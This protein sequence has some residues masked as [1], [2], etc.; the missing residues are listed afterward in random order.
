MNDPLVQANQLKKYYYK[1]TSWFRKK[2]I[3][4]RAIDNVSFSIPSGKIVGLIGESGSGKTTLA[5][6][7]SGLLSLTSGYLSFDNTP[8]NLHS[9]HDLKKLRSHVRM[10]FQNPKASLNPRKT[11][12]DSLGHAL[13]HHRIITKDKLH[14]VIGETLERVGLSAD[15]FYY[16]PHQLSGGQQ[17][18]VSIAR[19]LLG[20]PKLIICDEVVSA[21][22]LSMQAQILNML[23]KLQ[24][25]LQMSYLFISHDLAVV[26]S[27]CSEVIIMYKG[28]IVE[29]GATED[30]FLNPKHPYTQMLLNSQLADLPEN[31]SIEHKLKSFQ[32]NSSENPSPT[33]C[34]FY[35]RCP[36]RQ[37][38]CLQGPIPEQ[39]EGD[40]HT[41]LC[42]L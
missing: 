14:S 37:K 2:T 13:I 31:R 22:D 11:I 21:L 23:A 29:S 27:F 40:K 9:R 7:L 20:A 17:Q 39:T 32:K 12:F 33:G 34:V 19:A 16:Y 36:K 42:I 6:A 10:V 35:N 3:A 15:Y 26:R 28:K 5:L 4:M 18:R 38:T 30:I 1:R 41:Y 25:E 8:I 24:K